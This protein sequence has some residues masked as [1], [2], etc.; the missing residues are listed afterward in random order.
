MLAD[1][2]L[3]CTCLSSSLTL[4]F[5]PTLPTSSP[6][7]QGVLE[8]GKESTAGSMSSRDWRSRLFVLCRDPGN[9]T[10]SLYMYKDPK[11]KWQK[12]VL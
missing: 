9:K 2:H 8:L 5:L 10:S 6:L 4:H 7:S 1:F 12:Q 3:S 11:K